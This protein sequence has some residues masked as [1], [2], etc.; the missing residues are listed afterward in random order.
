MM[1]ASSRSNVIP[2]VIPVVGARS[3]RSLATLVKSGTSAKTGTRNSLAVHRQALANQVAPSAYTRRERT[4]LLAR[5]KLDFNVGLD[6]PLKEFSLSVRKPYA[7]GSGQLYFFNV[8]D[9]I[10]EQDRAAL[11]MSKLGGGSFFSVIVHSDTPGAR[12]LLDVSVSGSPGLRLDSV[13]GDASATADSKG[14]VLMVIT[15]GANAD[16]AISLGVTGNG[17]YNFHNVVISRL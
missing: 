6:L 9:Y 11:F 10:P 14:H 13:Y 3:L 12:Y 5:A 2:V 16:A 4:A 17:M 8:S 7:D 1:K 15:T